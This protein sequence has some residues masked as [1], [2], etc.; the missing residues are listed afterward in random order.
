[1]GTGTCLLNVKQSSTRELQPAMPLHRM[2]SSSA[3]CAPA[4]ADS[5]TFSLKQLKAQLALR[6]GE[7][8][9]QQCD[10]RIK[11]C[12][13]AHIQSALMPTGG[14]RGSS[15]A[16]GTPPAAGTSPGCSSLKRA[17]SSL[18]PADG[19]D[20]G[21]SAA[22]QLLPAADA[23]PA[24]KRLRAGVL[25]GAAD[26]EFDLGQ[27]RTLREML[28]AKFAD[29]AVGVTHSEAIA[30]FA[31]EV[32]DHCKVGVTSRPWQSH[33]QHCC[34]RHPRRIKNH[35]IKHARVPAG[36]GRAAGSCGS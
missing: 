20:A 29:P 18:L 26:E 17:S 6:Y 13:A 27:D 36:H 25:G 10:A 35:R 16:G 2:A 1:M 28:L 31:S 14:G 34:M 9:V 21:R 4:G 11:A 23:E 19:A 22:E 12:V 7:A 24:A 32:T 5:T 3:A 33:R 30:L 8:A 15:P